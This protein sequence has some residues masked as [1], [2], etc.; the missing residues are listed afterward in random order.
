LLRTLIVVCACLALS[1]IAC[2][3]DGGDD[4]AATAESTATTEAQ[5]TPVDDALLDEVIELAVTLGTMTQAQAAC[6]FRDHPSIYHEFLQNSGLDES[7][8][9][10]QEEIRAQLEALKRD[11]AVQLDRCF[12]IA[13]G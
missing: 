5:R 4:P 7:G 13:G 10:D 1:A 6:V 2:G 3:S 12:I 11:Y 8:L 9:Y